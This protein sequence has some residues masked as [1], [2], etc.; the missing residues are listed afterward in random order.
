MKVLNFPLCLLV[1]VSS[2]I[3]KEVSAS[4]SKKV[5]IEQRTGRIYHVLFQKSRKV[6]FHCV[7]D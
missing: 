5:Q 3:K 6:I 7:E 2:S 4:L 1:L